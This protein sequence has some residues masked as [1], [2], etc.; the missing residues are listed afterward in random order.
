NSGGFGA[1]PFASPNSASSGINNSAAMAVSAAAATAAIPRVNAVHHQTLIASRQPPPLTPTVS[2]DFLRSVEEAKA[3][4]LRI[5]VDGIASE[6]A[7]SR[8]ETQIKITLRLVTESGELVNC[9]SHLALPEMLVSREKFRHRLHKNPHSESSLPVSDQHVV[10]LE[11]KIICSSDPTRKVETCIGCIRREYK[12]SLRRKDNRLRSAAPSTCTTPAQ[13]RPGSPTG[14]G[15]GGRPMTGTMEMDWDERRI[16][17]EKQRIVIFNCNDLLEFSKGEVI[18][19]TRITC[20]CRHHNEKVGFCVCFTLKDAQGNVLAT[21]MTAPIMITDDHKSTKFKTDRKT[22]GRAEYDRHGEG[23]AAYANHALAGSGGGGGSSANLHMVDPS[24]G[25]L[26]GRQAMSARNSP[27]MR[28]FHHHPLLDTYSQFASLAGTPS[29]GNTPL[30]SPMLSAASL[31]G[32]DSSFNLPQSAATSMFG[33]LGGSPSTAQASPQTLLPMSQQQRQQQQQQQANNLS[34][35]SSQNA[36]FQSMGTTAAGTSAL[37]SQLSGGGQIE[38]IQIGQLMPAQGPVA[39]G[40]NILITGH[41]FHPNIAVYFG[42]GRA[43]RLQVLSS[44][45]LT[46]V[47][48]PTNASG[49]VPILIRDLLTMNIYE[50]SGMLVTEQQLQQQ[51]LQQQMVQVGKPGVFKYVEDTDQAM[52]DLALQV[53]GLRQGSQLGKDDGSMRAGGSLSAQVSPIMQNKSASSS[54]MSSPSGNSNHSPIHV[55]SQQQQQQAGTNKL[56]QDPNV[57]TTLRALRIASEQRNLVEIESSLVKLFM[58]LINKGQ[59]EPNRLSMKHDTNGRTLL[60]FS[61]LLGMLTL[62]TFLATHGVVLDEADNSGLTA[63]HFASMFGRTEIVEVLLNSGASTS[64]K[65]GLGHPAVDLAREA[66]H[67]GILNLFE[68]REG[69]MSF[70]K[71]DPIESAAA[72]A[73]AVAASGDGGQLG[74][75]PQVTIGAGF[76]VNVDG[77]ISSQG[78][79]GFSG[80][81]MASIPPSLFASGVPMGNNPAL[82]FSQPLPQGGLASSSAQQMNLSATVGDFSQHQQ[83]QQQR[84]L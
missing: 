23:N 44:S 32:F 15:P 77:S 20:Y 58:T 60:H 55:S 22:R 24:S 19:P 37:M 17:V 53:I 52:L 75:L 1:S 6:N 4:G 66:G 51:Q 39:G 78:S 67:S 8:V 14:D 29:I 72:A 40:A 27:T 50:P 5:E 41:G 30:G 16:E 62:L 81:T 56:F 68:E 57:L 43:S 31:A 61:A 33:N 9:W 3:K 13:S 12:R 76:S 80:L 28:P 70:I 64:I 63:L 83:Q 48:P 65:S 71:D 49:P 10:S 11:A 21:H 26:P 18:L 42:T 59:L 84:Q 46:C 7:K 73:A 2:P 34:L 35:L 25:G 79:G 74:L 36:L 47:L 69:Y 38:P 82:M 45:N 54:R